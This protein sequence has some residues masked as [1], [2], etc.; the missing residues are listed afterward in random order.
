MRG[1]LF[2]LKINAFPHIW[3]LTREWTVE[4]EGEFNINAGI[5]FV[6]DNLNLKKVIP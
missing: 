1:L 4:I 3:Q 5:L 2:P 6:V